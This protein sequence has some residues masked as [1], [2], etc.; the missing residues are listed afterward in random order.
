M[1]NPN[2]ENDIKTVTNALNNYL[3]VCA[4]QKSSVIVQRPMSEILSNLNASDLIKKG[5]LKDG[6]LEQ[7]LESYLSNST[8]LH[9][10]NYMGHQVSV[11]HPTGALGSYIDGF[12]NNA[13]A[14][15]EMGPAATALEVFMINWMLEHIGWT[16][17][18]IN[19]EYDANEYASGVM[20][21]GGSL[22]NLTALVTARSAKFPDIWENGTPANLVVLVPEQS[23]YSLKR[24]VGILGIG[25]K[26]CIKMPADDDGRVLPEEIPELINDLK[27]KGKDILAIVGNACGT[28]AGLY[29]PLDKIGDICA[30]HNIW[31]HVDAA[32]GAGAIVSEKYRHLVKGIRKADSIIWDAHKMF[33]TP[34]LCAALLVKKA[35]HLDGAFSQEASYL[36]HDKEQPGVDQ[37]MRA[38]ECT[39]SGLGLKMFMTIAAMGE[40]G[41]YDYIESR[42]DLAIEA[43]EY[44][45]SLDDFECPVTPETSILCFRIGN[46]NQR[47]LDIRKELLKTGEYYIST[48]EYKKARWLRCVLINP[49]TDMGVIKGL[50][51]KV[52]QINAELG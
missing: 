1:K 15:Y 42:T 40:N 27:S 48:T 38:V 31:F 47:Q 13:M 16:P 20:T 43:S 44:I 52:R 9:H 46:D 26:N 7:F 35:I 8:K 14:I 5:N 49:D 21:H 19:E 22:A 2:F 12:T 36:V 45:N 39:K 29:D 17:A 25:E 23:H 30:E 10:K 4:N 33:R 11:P 34:V 50:I 3:D 18:P 6:N 28:A 41:I 24:T 51:E 32:H 37:M